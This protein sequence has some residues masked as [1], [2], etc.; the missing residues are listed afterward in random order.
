MGRL[1]HDEPVAEPPP[2]ETV[3]L[4]S[5]PAATAE[6]T[7]EEMVIVEEGY[8]GVERPRPVMAVRRREFDR[9]FARLLRG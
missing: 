1:P 2:V 3:P 5:E 4:E 6:T 7:A 8:D 9:L